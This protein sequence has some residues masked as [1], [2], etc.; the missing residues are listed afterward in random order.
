MG[1]IYR[2]ALPFLGCDL[3]AMVLIM[4]VPELTL[5]LPSVMID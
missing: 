2:A 5:W 3:I 4:T 1:D